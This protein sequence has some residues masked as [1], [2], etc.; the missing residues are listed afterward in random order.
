LNHTGSHKLNNCL[1]QA[2]LAKRMGKKRVIAETGGGQHGVAAATVSALLGLE[3]HVFMGIEDIERQQLN[4]FRMKMLGAEVVPVHSGTATL[5]DATTEAMRHWIS[6]VKTTNYLIGSVVGPHPFPLMVREFQSVIGEECLAQLPEFG[7]KTPD[8]I[9]ACVGGGS[10]SM[11][12]FHP[13]KESNAQL[14]GVEAG[15]RGSNIGEHA[16]SLSLGHVGVFHGEKSYFLQDKFGQI[17]PAYSVSAGLDY[18]GVGPE[19]AF[20]KT[21]G[22]A[23]YVT[24]SDQEAI[25]A[26]KLLSSAEGIIPALESAHAIAYAIKLARTFAQEQ[27]ILV[28]LSGRGDKDIVNLQ[29]LEGAK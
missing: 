5:K 14:I 1:G 9:I 28:N 8:Y 4:V 7:I 19:H 11:G 26:F 21:S 29:K 22:R 20:Y 15:G 13:F 23:E 3:C 6:T 10:N 24:V 16:A 18:P 12:I 25:D 17:V 2:L 27:I